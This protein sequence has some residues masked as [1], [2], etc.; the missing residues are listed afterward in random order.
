MDQS[1]FEFL[2]ERMP[3]LW[4]RLGQHLGLTAASTAMAIAIGVPLGVVALRSRATKSVVLSSV[5]ILQTIPSLALLTLLLALLNRIGAVPAII[6]LTLYALL[7]I[8]RNTITGLEG[9]PTGVMNAADGLGMT[10]WQQLRMVQF[11]LALPVIIAGI[12]TAAVIGV[13]VAT[14]SAFIGAGGLGQ[15]INRG[16]AL[17]NPRLILLGAIPSAM[18]ALAVD[19]ALASIGW[20][21]DPLRKSSRP[22]STTR[23][24]RA[25]ALVIPLVALASGM[26]TYV[27][28]RPNL[29]IGSKAFSESIILGHMMADLI[30]ANTDLMVERRFCLGGTMICHGALVSG[31]VDLYPEYTGTALTA[32]LHQ[33]A[34]S[35]PDKV[36]GKVANAYHE[37]FAVA[38][39]PPLG[40]NN[41]YAIA[42]RERD[43]VE[44][45]WTKISDL[46]Q[47]APG[48]K[49]GWTA[50]FAE[51]PDGYPGLVDRYGFE[52][53]E[54]IDFEASLMYEAT[55]KGEVD[56]V[57]AYSTDGRIDANHLV[58][59]ED[60]LQF[61][62]P[63]YAVPVVR[64]ATLEQ[65]P[66]LRGILELLSG[67]LDN[68]TMQRLNYE[69]DGHK[70]SPR[71]V[72][73][74][75]LVAEGVLDPSEGAIE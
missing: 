70:R 8:V 3:E 52:F 50:E 61:F 48:L 31:E 49:A 47:D 46:K 62:P 9:V 38:V 24:A 1:W 14:L 28:T 64:E 25:A 41:T 37:Q 39:L 69:V 56:V 60:D 45:G 55:S 44:N 27:G 13:G 36:F 21:L 7:P 26:A 32:V 35:D 40:V 43:A 30:E 5:A 74:E 15:F 65:Y 54:A 16:L 67:R 19:G 2:R 75:F 6:A 23:V 33:P 10:R 42:V 73:R 11:P 63:Y 29:V 12:R 34:I 4:L 72:A 68:Q 58:L 53:G 59:L 71:E 20:A 18:L 57:A 51:R 66:Q 22:R 17:D